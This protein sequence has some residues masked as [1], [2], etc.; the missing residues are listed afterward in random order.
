MQTKMTIR[1]DIETVR[2]VQGTRYPDVS[3]PVALEGNGVMALVF[4]G[5][6]EDIAPIMRDLVNAR[7][8]LIMD[9]AL[10][11]VKLHAESAA[12]SIDKAH[13]EELAAKVA[14]LIADAAAPEEVAPV[15]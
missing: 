9:A 6:P 14:A 8:D 4:P 3:A 1:I 7:A 11:S 12:S 5:A 10:Q 15:L 2:N 13:D